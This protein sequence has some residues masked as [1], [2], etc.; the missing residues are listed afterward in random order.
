MHDPEHI[1][2]RFAVSE[3]R[4]DSTSLRFVFIGILVLKRDSNRVASK[5][6][7]CHRIKQVAIFRFQSTTFS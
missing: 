4:Q 3:S 2:G 6:E 1:A 5:E 7:R